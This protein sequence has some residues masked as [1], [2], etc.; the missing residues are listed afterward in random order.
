M[1]S[2]Y[3]GLQSEGGKREKI[4][5]KMQK[6]EMQHKSFNEVKGNIIEVAT[7]DDGSEEQNKEIIESMKTPTG[8]SG[9][10]PKLK[11]KKS[12]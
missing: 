10:T 9:C 5:G 8:Y 1:E 7:H 12:I 6:Q 4:V 11:E 3:I 2:C